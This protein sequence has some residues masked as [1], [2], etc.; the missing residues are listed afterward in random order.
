[1]EVLPQS[2]VGTTAANFLT[3]PVGA[4]ASAMGGAF[5]ALA[6]NA[7]TIHWNP[8]GLSRLEGNEV[9]ATYAAWLADTELNWVGLNVKIGD[10]AIGISLNQL[11]YGEEEITTPDDQLGTGQYWS[12]EDLAIGVT[13]ARNLTDRFSIG[14]TA[15]YISERIWNESA[16]AYALDVGL[17]FDTQIHGLRLGM[18]LANFGTEMQLDGK[19]LLQP[20]DIDPAHPGNNENIASHLRTDS[21]TL[22]LT[23]TMGV[24]M[25]VMQLPASRWTIG[26]DATYPNNQTPYINIGSEFLWNNLIALRTGY[27]SLFKQAAEEGLTLGFG[28][29]FTLGQY[30]T[31]ID[32]SYIDYDRFN[33]VSRYEIGIQF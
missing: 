30:A 16:S 13:Y 7:T 29:Q 28:L 5:V 1:M 8:G 9:I 21:W 3:I 6:D 10:N 25:D 17:L 14:G 26:T 18:N 24:A 11:N 27:N 20:V 15:K 31:R 12:A 19:D 32:Y 22:P 2:K 4:R 33:G 23:F